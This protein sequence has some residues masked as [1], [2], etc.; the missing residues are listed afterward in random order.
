MAA[1]GRIDQKFWAHFETQAINSGAAVEKL[2]M[3]GTRIDS[4]GTD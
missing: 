1:G 2:L 3:A 4:G